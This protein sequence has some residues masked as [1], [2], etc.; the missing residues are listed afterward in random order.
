M[1]ALKIRQDES[2]LV[3]QMWNVLYA[4]YYVY[5]R[6]FIILEN[7]KLI[8]FTFRVDVMKYHIFGWYLYTEKYFFPKNILEN[9]FGYTPSPLLPLWKISGPIILPMLWCE[10]RNFF[11]TNI[12]AKD[13]V[14]RKTWER[15]SKNVFLFCFKMCWKLFGNG[16]FFDALPHLFARSSSLIVAEWQR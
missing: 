2:S 4:C 7:W 6:K 13:A 5:F 3:K 15:R 12:I 10:L 9:I 16:Y 8:Y 14:W 1:R 11:A